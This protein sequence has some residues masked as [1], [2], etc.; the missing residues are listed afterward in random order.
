[1]AHFGRV[2]IVLSPRLNN[3]GCHDWHNAHPRKTLNCK[4]VQRSRELLNWS[5][6][7]SWFIAHA[8][9]IF[10]RK[11]LQWTWKKKMSWIGSSFRALRKPDPSFTNS[12]GSSI[13]SRKQPDVPPAS[14]WW[15]RLQKQRNFW[16]SGNSVRLTSSECQATWLPVRGDGIG[17]AIA[18]KHSATLAKDPSHG[19][20]KKKEKIRTETWIKLSIKPEEINFNQS[21]IFLCPLF[22]GSELKYLSSIANTA[23]NYPPIWLNCFWGSLI[24]KATT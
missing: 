4:L 15:R 23:L 17:H 8:D 7:V 10:Q 20:R 3:N 12:Y 1:M 11:I 6:C 21:I 19:G 13:C 24:V 14:S 9:Q 18:D 5:R 22:S 2:G 16:K